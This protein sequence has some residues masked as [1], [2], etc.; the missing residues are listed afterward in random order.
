LSEA[1]LRLIDRL[2]DLEC[3]PKRSA[4]EAEVSA[5]FDEF[6]VPLLRYMNSLGLP[7]ADGED[8]VQEVFLSLFHHLRQQK[9]RDNLR[10]WIF[11]VAHNLAL[12]RRMRNG[13]AA[14]AS[15]ALHEVAL[16]DP[17]P[18]PEERTAMQGANH[19]LLAVVKTLPERERN[20]LFLRAEGLRYREIAEA[21]DM[22]LGGVALSLSR[23]LGKL[24]SVHQR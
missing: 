12:K 22:S 13:R 18:N 7:F 19:R 16:A 6:R 24:A 2:A 17:A 11:R 14:V 8:V 23:A 3:E 1:S 4:I 5:M 21:L 15:T 9:P 20:C 10:G